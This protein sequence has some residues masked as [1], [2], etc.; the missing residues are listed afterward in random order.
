RQAVARLLSAGGANIEELNTVRKQLSR[1]K[2]GGVA[3]ACRAGRLITL[4]IS[5][6]LGDRLDVIASGPT[7][8]D[9]RTP[10]E[11][12]AI[13]EPYTGGDERMAPETFRYLRKKAEAERPERP[14]RCEVTNLIIGNNAVAVDAAGVEAERHGYS[15]AMVA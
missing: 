14:I 15:H 11:A 4:I 6:V 2:G 12:L 5:D 8:P 3:R 1:I 7:V 13:L 10:Q 9:S